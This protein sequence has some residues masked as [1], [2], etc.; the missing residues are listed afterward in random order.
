MPPTTR[1][2]NRK[3]TSSS[4]LSS[5]VA[6][7]SCDDGVQKLF[8]N[9]DVDKALLNFDAVSNSMMGNGHEESHDRN[10]LIPKMNFESGSVGTRSPSPSDLSDTSSVGSKRSRTE[11]KDDAED[12]NHNNT[13]NKRAAVPSSSAGSAAV[14]FKRTD[15]AHDASFERG[16]PPAPPARTHAVMIRMD[17]VRDGRCPDCG[18]ETH[19][20]VRR[21]D[22]SFAREPLN[23]DGEVLNGR[24]LFCNPLDDVGSDTSSQQFINNVQ[25]SGLSPIT[26]SA[27]WP[28]GH[29][30]GKSPAPRK[31]SPVDQ[32]K[33]ISGRN[34][35]TDLHQNNSKPPLNKLWEHRRNDEGGLSVSSVSCSDGL[36][37]VDSQSV[38]TDDGDDRSHRSGNSGGVGKLGNAVAAGMG[39]SSGRETPRQQFQQRNRAPDP[40]T[41]KSIPNKSPNPN[42]DTPM[43]KNS[44]A[45][46]RRNSSEE[47]LQ[48]DL[49]T[50]HSKLPSSIYHHHQYPMDNVAEQ[51]FIEKTRSYLESGSGDICDVIA[52]MRRFPFSLSIQRVACEK[53]YVHCFER[54]HA[55][56]IGVSGGIRTIID[57]M[58]YHP[59]DAALQH[60]CAGMIK[61]LACASLYNLDM[62]DRMGAVGK[63]LA[64]MECHSQNAMLLESC[65]WAIEG[66]ARVHSPAFKMRVA[67]GGG[68]HAAMKAV[69]T[70]PDN[71]ALLRAA[72]HCL[73]QL[74]YNP[75]SFGYQQQMGG[76]PQ[77]ISMANDNQKGVGNS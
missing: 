31:H 20:V 73:R 43:S 28:S 52:A 7:D 67:R 8:T 2:K 65:C 62:L 4:P 29:N 51:A 17:R 40:P 58:E 46:V 27:H 16:R 45:I 74:G 1:I 64:T 33:L 56:A 12:N 61:H 3:K 36:D 24:C 25:H 11:I 9:T 49:V 32:A 37:T 38:L 13:A 15:G 34:A 55:H 47:G 54:D 71:D 63:L 60:T 70:F 66:M 72:F 26:S 76:I 23:I 10:H 57:A 75:S 18:L 41:L 30:R 14:D 21:N 6:A 48:R 68:I 77:S 69:E 5:P 44:R 19:S 35:P 42:I 50:A 39:M 22:G 53:L 59:S